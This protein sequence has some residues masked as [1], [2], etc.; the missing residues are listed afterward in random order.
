VLGNL[1]SNAIKF[2]KEGSLII[3]E[4]KMFKDKVL[5]TIADQGIGLSPDER[6]NISTK[7]IRFSSTGTKGEL[8]TGFGLGIVSTY[9][10]QYGGKIS[11]SQNS[12]MGTIFT[13]ELTASMPQ[14]MDG[15][16]QDQDKIVEP[17]HIN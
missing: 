10:N 14:I 3:L 12:P 13:I 8:G 5:I 6:K 2:S 1:I 16:S 17:T 15:L 7:K 4:A 11:A 9:V